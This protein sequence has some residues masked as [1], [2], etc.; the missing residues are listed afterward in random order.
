MRSYFS[1]FG[2][3]ARLR[4]ARNKLSGA[5][6]HFG[7]IEFASL[8][9]A[10]IVA[11]TMDKYLMFGH[12]LQVRLIPREQV[13]PQLFK[14][15]GKRFKPVPRNKILGRSL[16]LGMDRKGWDI[17]TSKEKKKR[18]ERAE[19][20]KEMGYEFEAPE[21]RSVDVIPRRD[22]PALDGEDKNGVN[23]EE[24]PK[25]IQSEKHQPGETVEDVLKAQAI[26]AEKAGKEK[27]K[28]KKPKKSKAA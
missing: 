21:L 11:A 20:L 14:G 8:E 28:V 23:G 18:E 15:A 19:K 24:Q 10:K 5:S 7:F 16:R 9:V 4:L 17:R 3:L 27:V 1:Q 22:V 2:T 25:A 6:K 12:I 13:H 26:P